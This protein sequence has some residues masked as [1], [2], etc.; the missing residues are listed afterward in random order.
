[1]KW[2]THTD[3]TRL[4]IKKYASLADHTVKESVII[5]DTKIIKSIMERIES[6]PTEGG[7]MVSFSPDAKHM[8]LIFTCGKEVKTIE[9]FGESFKTP[10]THFSTDEAQI[11][12][13]S[14]LYKEIIG[15]LK[16]S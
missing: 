13:E 7:M 10:A 1:M 6:F 8:D 9:I 14:A 15:Y 4:E 5:E 16:K 12:I 11:Q 3:C 2:F